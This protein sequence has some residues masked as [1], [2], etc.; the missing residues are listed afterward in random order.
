MPRTLG[1]KLCVGFRK[2]VLLVTLI[3]TVLSEWLRVTLG[4]G[5]PFVV[6][7]RPDKETDGRVPLLHPQGCSSE[8]SIGTPLV[9]EGKFL[10]DSPSLTSRAELEEFPITGI[11]F[12]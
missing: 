9:T 5:A 6:V 3:C 2:S 4:T 7:S 1:F 12:F 11:M 10:S 8:T